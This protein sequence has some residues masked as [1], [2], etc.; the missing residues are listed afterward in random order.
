[1]KKIIFTIIAFIII[2]GGGYYFSVANS[3]TASVQDNGEAI[4]LNAQDMGTY[5]KMQKLAAALEKNGKKVVLSGKESF[6]SGLFNLYAASDIHNLPKVLDSKAINL[7][8][9]P[10][11]IDDMPEILRP[12]DVIVVESMGSF[13]HLKAINV[14]TAFIPP[15]VDMRYKKAYHPSKNYPM[16]YGDNDTGFSLSLYLAGPTDLR[17]DVYGNGFSGYWSESELIAPTATGSDFRHYPL[18]MVDQSE[19]N[20]KDEVVNAKIIEIIE[21]GGLPYVR[22]NPGIAK[23]F[24][25]AV[26]MYMTQDEFLPEIKRLLNAPNE[27]KE[28]LDAIRRIANSWNSDSQAKKFIELFDVMKKKMK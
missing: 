13:T 14:R 24:G 7:L 17:V 10:N 8:W 3:L 9:I 6:K 12:Y 18:V 26:P 20:I 1:M 5:S 22:Y 11:V 16:F 21:Q 19:D 25:E 4:Y 27:L 23:M 28:R 2:C 15:A